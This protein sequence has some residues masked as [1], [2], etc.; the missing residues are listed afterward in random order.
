MLNKPKG[1]ISA[2]SDKSHKTVV[3]LFKG[4]EHYGLFPVGRLDKNTTGLLI[5]TNDGKLTHELISPRRNKPKTYLCTLKKPFE[6]FYIQAIKEG[7]PLSDFF[8]KP[9]IVKKVSDNVCE[10]TI[11][12]GKYHQVKRMFTTLG[13]E[14]TEL[15]RLSMNELHIDE[16]LKPGEFKEL[17]EEELNIL[18]N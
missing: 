2:S 9:G 15:H 4:Y 1:V 10:L 7:I 5:I 12:E 8:T 16:T 18:K 14:I 13:N 3:D 17:S 6:N 11:F